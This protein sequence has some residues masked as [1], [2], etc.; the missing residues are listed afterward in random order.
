MPEFNKSGRLWQ[1]GWHVIANKKI[2]YSKIDKTGG[3]L[4]VE[5][6]RSIDSTAGYF[7]KYLYVSMGSELGHSIKPFSYSHNVLNEGDLAYNAA[8]N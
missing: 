6:I 5:D 7:C 1:L 4:K 2:N 3:G 8:F